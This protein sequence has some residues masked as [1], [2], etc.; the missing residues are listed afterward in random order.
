MHFGEPRRRQQVAQSNARLLPQICTER[1]VDLRRAALF[2][3]QAVT[4][5]MR[6]R[7]HA[8]VGQV[9]IHFR[10]AFPHV[11]H[12]L[13]VFARQQHVAQGRIIDH[14]AATG[15]DQPGAGLEAVEALAVEQVPGR[16]VAGLGQRR[17]QADHIA[18]L[19]DLRQ[20]DVIAA[21]GALPRRVAHQHVPAQALEH[22]DQPAAHFTGADHAVGARTEVGAFD[23]GQGLQAAQYVVHHAPCIAAGGAGP[24]DAGLFEVVQVQVIGADGA[25]TDKAHLRPCEQRTVDVGD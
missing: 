11:Q 9:D 14:R 10:L 7:Q 15:V 5:D 18:L 25:G 6:R 21:F 4:G 13:Q 8:Q 20:A 22:L 12:G 19:D 16:T 3:V 1:L 23:F 2:A 17:M 24:L